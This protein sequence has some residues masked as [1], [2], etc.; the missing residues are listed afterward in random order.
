[1]NIAQNAKLEQIVE[2]LNRRS[3]LIPREVNP[4]WIQQSAQLS[5]EDYAHLLPSDAEFR[6]LQIGNWLGTTD[7]QIISQA[8]AQVLPPFYQPEYDFVVNGLMLAANL[9]AQEGQQ[10]A[11]KVALGVIGVG[12]FFAALAYISREAA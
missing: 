5:V 2:F 8:V 7:G 3:D 10:A 6:S 11:G 4:Y 1:M 12:L 9:Q